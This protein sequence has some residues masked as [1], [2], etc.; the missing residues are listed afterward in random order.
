LISADV[1]DGLSLKKKMC[2]SVV[3][4]RQLTIVP[5]FKEKKQKLSIH[6]I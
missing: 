5:Q 6:E 2:A 3:E 1:Y 4:E